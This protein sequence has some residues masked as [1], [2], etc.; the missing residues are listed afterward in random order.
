MTSASKKAHQYPSPRLRRLD[1][2]KVVIIAIA[3]CA[4]L[5]IFVA[6]K[7]RTSD[8]ARAAKIKPCV[9]PSRVMFMNK[10]TCAPQ[11]PR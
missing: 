7:I 4:K 1:A 3:P 6:R 9:N 11:K 2:T 10:L 5:I 8:N